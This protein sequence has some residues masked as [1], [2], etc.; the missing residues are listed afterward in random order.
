V[1]SESALK[2]EPKPKKAET[3]LEV[4]PSAPSIYCYPTA[5]K[6][7]KEQYV[8]CNE[9]M[10]FAVPDLFCQNHLFRHHFVAS[11][12]GWRPIFCHSAP[13]GCIARSWCG[14]YET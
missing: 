14:L 13:Q 4:L 8:L 11:M 10:K 12:C 9:W 1:R 5:Q 3:S 7:A 6:L 2:G